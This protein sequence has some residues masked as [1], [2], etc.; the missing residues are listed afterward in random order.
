MVG[1]AFIDILHNPLRKGTFGMMDR[2]L[3]SLYK[4]LIHALDDELQNHARLLEIILEETQALRK[5]RLPEIL[6]VGTRKGDAFRQSEEAAQRRAEAVVQIVAHLGL[7]SPVSFVQMAAYADV[8]TRQVLIGYR[9]KF[10]D[11]VRRIEE[12]NEINRQIIAL[13]LAHVSNNLNFI[14]N[15][16]S[17]IPNYDQHG[18]IKAGNLQGRLISQ[19]G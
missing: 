4:R 6:D 8:A 18:Q 10:A 16:S 13:T 14:H 3:A 2:V 19:A 5:S 12:A 15:I 9:E 1:E 17:S 7:E 11:I